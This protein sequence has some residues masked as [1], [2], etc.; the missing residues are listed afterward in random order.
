MTTAEAFPLFPVADVKNA[1]GDEQ[2]CRRIARNAGW[3]DGSR[4]LEL[5][6]DGSALVLARELSCTVMSVDTDEAPLSRVRDEIRSQGLQ[7]RVKAKVV[8]YGKLPFAEGEFDGVLELGRVP[9]ALQDAVARFRPLLAHRGRLAIAFPVKIGSHPSRV[10]MDFWEKRLGQPLLYP[11]EVLQALEKGGFEPEGIEAMDAL[12]LDK[13]YQD[14]ERWASRFP[15]AM[16]PAR[17]EMLREEIN[18]HRS[19]GAKATV[20]LA[21]AIGRRREPG[22]KPPLSR[23]TG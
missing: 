8:D 13:F 1:F 4:V 3:G 11:R 15:E 23:D 19:Q 14:V 22:E 10:A 9:M 21:L 7:D 18:I 12:E 5:C 20:T 17:L 6:S 2:L 16:K